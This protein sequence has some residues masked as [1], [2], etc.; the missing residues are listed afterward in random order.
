M[1]LPLRHPKQECLRMYGNRP[2]P[3]ALR[4]APAPLKV[5]GDKRRAPAGA[6]HAALAG[7]LAAALGAAPLPLLPLAPA[8]PLAPTRMLRRLLLLRPSLVCGPR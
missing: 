7:A 8:L 1:L 4:L 5:R 2:P 3:P 6:L